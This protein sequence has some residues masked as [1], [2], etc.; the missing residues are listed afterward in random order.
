M[1]PFA[2]RY[3]A[4]SNTRLVE[5][6]ENHADYR[7]E[8]IIAAKEE[9]AKRNLSESD[10]EA[11]KAELEANRQFKLAQ[12]GKINGILQLG[13]GIWPLLFNGLASIYIHQPIEVKAFRAT[14]TFFI[15][16]TLLGWFSLL[17]FLIFIFT[18]ELG[19][20]DGSVFLYIAPIL[21]ATIGTVLFGL[22][23]TIGWAMMAIHSTITLFS[24]LG[25]WLI[26]WLQRPP[27]LPIFEEFYSPY[28]SL[29]EILV[30]L[31]LAIVIRVMFKPYMR[32]YFSV[33]RNW[34]QGT[35]AILVILALI[36]VAV[37]VG[38]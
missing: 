8:A 12:K 7:E 5:I 35:L 29:S 37:W 24:L 26:R 2:E 21:F 23:K 20:W 10:W 6:I 16:Q 33:G 38:T 34:V 18:D 17:D 1:N 13:P 25:T 30:G 11:A 3:Q 4:F 27:D 9:L 36:L 19:G 22:K 14:L 15:L 32:Q 31:L 28:P